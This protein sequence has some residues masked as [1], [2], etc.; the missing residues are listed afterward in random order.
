MAHVESD[1][2]RRRNSGI[3]YGWWVVA[4]SSAM[5][6]FASGIFF[7]GFAVFFRPV[8]DHLDLSD[9]QTALVFSIARAEGG[10]EGPAAGWAIDRFGNRTLLVAG[11]I[12]AAAGYLVFSRFVNS[13]WSFALV[14]LGMISLGNTVA[15][16][17]AMFAGMNNWFRRRR[18]LAISMMAAVASL[19]GLVMVP[20]VSL[21]ILR[22]SWQWAV[23]VAGAAYLVGI[24]PLTLIFRNRP[25]DKGLLP[26]G[27]LTPPVVAASGPGRPGRYDEIRDYTVS[28]A[29]RTRAYWL[30]LLGAGLRQIATMG[31]Q[32]NIVP[33]L[34]ESKGVS[35]Q[36]A[37]NL[38]GL[39][40]GINFVA[41]L[42]LGYL[43]DR[44]SK[45][46]M[47]AATLALE[48]VAFLCL[49]LGSWG[50]MGTL[51]V[52]LFVLLEG[53]GDGAGVIIWAALGE[54][55]GRDRFA[56]LRGI[57]T[58]SHSWAQVGSPLFTGWVKDRYGTHSP[59]LL[60]AIIFAAVASVC[61]LLIQKPPQ[62]TWE[63]A[64]AADAGNAG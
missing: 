10:L 54:Y 7:R 19:G 42:S 63:P 35:E 2:G 47:L 58:F 8:R 44:W 53:L 57:V 61:F 24:L 43:G 38:L 5:I 37:A 25:E 46:W 49:L 52:L 34:V 39:M 11:I 18:S 15:F 13:F 56:T 28:E 17:H 1:T 26:D 32:V 41:R 31:I 62:L 12:L 64:E 3:F 29:L 59:A 48:S 16:Q 30:L 36:T 9:A 4:A 6:F 60:G 14:Y 33:I 20:L 45:S 21:I 22:V 55:Y 40:F 27:D 50:G 51:L 23:F